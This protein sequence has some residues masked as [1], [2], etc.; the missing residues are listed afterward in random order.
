MKLNKKLK[1]TEITCISEKTDLK[2]EL[3]ESLLI[4]V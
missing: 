3:I 4:F 2:L 1:A